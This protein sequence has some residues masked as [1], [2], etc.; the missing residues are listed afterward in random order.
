MQ[1]QYEGLTDSQWENIKEN[2]PIKKEIW[3]I[4][5]LFI[6]KFQL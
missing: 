5:E 4:K 3:F 2:L 1:I 6:I